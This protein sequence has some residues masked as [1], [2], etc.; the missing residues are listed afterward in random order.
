MLLTSMMLGISSSECSQ[1]QPDQSEYWQFMTFLGFICKVKSISFSQLC[2]CVWVLKPVRRLISRYD[3]QATVLNG[4]IYLFGGEA[5]RLD[6]KTDEWTI[7][8]EA[9]LVR[10][11]FTGGT[12][13]SGQI[14][15]LGERKGNKTLP[16]MILLDPYTDTCMEIDNETPCPVPVRGCVTVRF[17]SWFW[18]LSS[19]YHCTC[20]VTISSP[21]SLH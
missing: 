12:T 15:L 2:V 3:L 6:V 13:S 8:D 20:T 14:F 1:M 11:F 4:A 16:N 7:L 10:K 19:M 5:L 21:T 9:C 17:R 18:M